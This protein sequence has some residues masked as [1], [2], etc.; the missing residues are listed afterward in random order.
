MSALIVNNPIL[1]ALSVTLLHFI[2]QGVLVACI[3]KIALSIISHRRPNL[4]YSVT[5]V[6]MLTNLALPAL[7][8]LYIYQPI[9]NQTLNPINIIPLESFQ[10]VLQQNSSTLWYQQGAEYLPYLSIAWLLWVL[11][12]TTKLLFEIGLVQRLPYQDTIDAEPVLASRFITLSKQIGLHHTPRLVISL[13]A[14]VPMAIGWLKPVVLMPAK[15][16]M[17]LSQEQLE[18]LLLHELA[19]IKRYDYLVNFFQTLIEIL[20]FFHPAVSWVSKQMR[21]E[22][23][24]CSDD[25][26]VSHCGDNSIA[27]AH[28]LADT[29]ALCR[30]HRHSTIPT[31]AMAASGGDLKARVV[32]LVDHSCTNQQDSGRWLAAITIVITTLFI[33]SKQ[34]VSL[35]LS[36]LPLANSG[37]FKTNT[38]IL[39]SQNEPL[40]ATSIARQLLM[41]EIK[42]A[43]KTNALSGNASI[44]DTPQSEKLVESQVEVA[45][46]N[47]ANLIVVKETQA[48][49]HQGT[50]PLVAKPIASNQG[51]KQQKLASKS[52]NGSLENKSVLNDTK[53]NAN[54]EVKSVNK[55]L[56]L[57]SN[58]ANFKE[59]P[60]AKDLKELAKDSPNEPSKLAQTLTTAKETIPTAVTENSTLLASTDSEISLF[61][62]RYQSTQRQQ[63]EAE[64]LKEDARLVDAVDPKY[65]SV[66]KRKGIELEVLVNFTIDQQGKVTD[67]QFTH[68]SRLS[69]FR[70]SIIAAM[71]QWQFEPA[72][73]NGE[74]VSSSM[75]KIF[76]FNMS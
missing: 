17:G 15:M 70:S 28:T 40:P 51:A 25:I 65:P 13:K 46:K 69:Y 41:P 11:F 26:A 42:A 5:C 8:F 60:Y 56:L 27:Y 52:I 50:K 35:P 16:I 29:A 21:Q 57:T 64:M 23:E 22:R 47:E 31:M 55:K 62:Q 66:A 68:Q 76:S 71:E 63:L 48:I 4:R 6:A 58:Q 43:T 67:I 9:L 53:P 72:R 59:N 20:L 34:F 14:Q 73:V 49:V 74:P 36:E 54:N 2:W 33:A 7:T 61:E 75:S 18:M 1:Q 12:L 32:R 38:N 37:I 19:H 10:Q 3:L 24:Y 44:D 39:V 30:S 45:V